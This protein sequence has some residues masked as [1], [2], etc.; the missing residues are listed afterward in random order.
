MC[1]YMG[2]G[3][4]EDIIKKLLLGGMPT[5]RP[6]AIVSMGTLPK[7]KKIITTLGKLAEH[8]KEKN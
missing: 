8:S 2:M 7:Q 6:A 1:I 5:D 4:L 3:K